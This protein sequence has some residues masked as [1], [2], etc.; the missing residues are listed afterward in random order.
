MESASLS[1]GFSYSLTSWEALCANISDEALMPWRVE[2][3]CFQVSEIRDK[4]DALFLVH[5]E[6]WS[7]MPGIVL[8]AKLIV[9][10]VLDSLWR[11]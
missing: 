4:H 11:D 5:K 6:K 8:Q 1:P 2:T 10:K 3:L 9:P 7:L